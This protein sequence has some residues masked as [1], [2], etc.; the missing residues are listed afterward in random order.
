V[1]WNLEG[2]YFE[3]CNCDVVCP[4][5]ASSLTLPAHYERCGVLFM[6]HVDRG[7]I[8]GTDVSGLSIALLADTPAMMA[9]G[10]WRVGVFM[11]AAA[12]EEQAELLG[13]VFG[14][15]KGG[16]MANFAPLIGEMLGIERQPIEY[17]NGG[18]T[19]S[20]KIGDV[21]EIELQDFVP[22][23]LG[24]TTRLTNVAHPMNTTITVARATKARINAFGMEFEN[25]GKNG[26][27]APFSWSA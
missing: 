20:V 21:A 25:D 14:G 26:H 19:H 8:E 2:T 16:P 4:C 27:A 6:F 3:N 9:E 1:A 24:E 11:D 23:Q 15:Q 22:E 17:T 5:S 10:G 18:R 12:S 7:E 13:A